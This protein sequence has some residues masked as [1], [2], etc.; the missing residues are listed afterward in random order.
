MRHPS[1]LLSL[2][3]LASV[4]AAQANAVPGTDVN[5]YDVSASTIYGR[6]GGAYPTGEVGIG[7]GH[8]FCNG[9]TV[10]V[11]WAT[12]PTTGGPMTDVH[13]K[14]A[15]LLA[16]ESN[17]RIVQ[18]STP[19]SFVK[20]SRV[21]YNLGSSQCG[22][23]QAGPASTFRMGC[24]D[25]YSTGFN[26]N[27]FN[28]GPPNEIDPWTGSWNPVG[29]YFDRGDP[30]V[31]GAAATDGVQSLTSTQ[32]NAFDVVKNRVVVPESELSQPGVYFG[33]VQL[34][35]EGEPVA[36]RSNNLLSDQINF[37][38]NGTAWSTSNVGG[39]VA[40]SVLNRWA[41]STRNLGGNG[42]DDGR[43]LVA[44]KVTGPVDGVYHYEYA[45]HN[46]D[47]A[48]G[49]ASFKL[50]LH[51]DAQLTAVGFRDNNGNALDDWSWSRTGGELAFLASGTNSLDWNTLYNFWFDATVAP[52]SGSVTID[53]ARVGAGALS[54]AVANDV[55]NGAP[56]ATVASLGSGCFGLGLS[57]TRPVLGTTAQIT[58]S[59]IPAGTTLGVTVLSFT[60]APAPIDLSAIGMPTC[61]AY[62]VGGTN[63]LWLNPVGTAQVPLVVPNAASL[64]GL[65]VGA[66]SVSASPP[67]T[68]LGFIASNGVLM[69][70]GAQ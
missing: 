36:N 17:G 8:A 13:F 2:V 60:P 10:H 31:V 32:T 34:V 39:P 6:R 64:N 63:E 11:P 19:E 48:R 44:C 23:C 38:W 62:V 70:V 21:T 3:G 28:L 49:G 57:A 5:L 59:G 45:V 67:L 26:G 27:R 58:T 16:R 66:Q 15:F 1:F 61:F 30:A 47:N 69:V 51:P 41:G 20:H 9:G 14:I 7:F 18:V 46:I 22:T 50:P 52:T 29:S 55:P 53:Q 43:F 65:L 40:G 68:P 25:A 42:T 4:A 54:V 37:T 35:C 12:S 24:Y 56:S 33:Q